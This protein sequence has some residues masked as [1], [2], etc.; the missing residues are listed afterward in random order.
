MLTR[1]KNYQVLTNCEHAICT[2]ESTSYK[3]A[4]RHC[5]TDV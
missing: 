4:Q 3:E 1:C 2:K 5:Q